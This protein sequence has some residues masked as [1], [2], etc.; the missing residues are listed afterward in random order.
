NMH[1]ESYYDLPIISD[2]KATLYEHGKRAIT[3]ALRFGEHGLPFMGSGDWNDGMNM[4]GIG[5]KG[6]SVWLGFFLYDVLNR[7]MKLASLR[8]DE[9]FADVCRHNMVLLEENINKNAW[10]GKWYRRAYFDD[11]TPLGSSSNEECRI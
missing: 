6:E 8:G 4:V 11:G 2:R 1:E 7:F 9:E 5:G 10:D 3:H